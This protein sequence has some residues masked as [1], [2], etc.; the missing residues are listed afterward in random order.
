M[1]R[2]N[3]DS[4]VSLRIGKDQLSEL[5]SLA[6]AAESSVSAVIRI[7]INEF[8]EKNQQSVSQISSNKP[9]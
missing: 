3:R 1:K 4:L 6:N 5:V 7:A 9:R 2:K 8:A